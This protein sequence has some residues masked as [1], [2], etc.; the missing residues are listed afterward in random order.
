[1]A[2]DTYAG[3]KTTVADWLHRTDLTAQVPDFISLAERV[4]NRRLN[5]FPREIE[6]SIVAPTSGRTVS[7][8]SDYGQP[9]A[10]YLTDIDPREQLTYVLPEQLN[11]DESASLR[12]HYW[13]VDGANIAFESKSDQAYTMTF[14]YQ[15]NTLLSDSAPM[16]ATFARYPDLYLYGALAQ[17][18]PY[19][20]DDARWPA[21]A[22][23][24]KALL[25]EAAQ[26]ATMTTADA[27][28]RT[29]LVDMMR[30]PYYDGRTEY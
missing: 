21:W 24:F 10:L 13:A 26:D 29:E 3:L 23:N 15:Q 1:M 2:Y 11:V 6:S 5:I 22:A 8:P 4:I 7:L 16:H 18:A 27:E 14:R 9:L 12:P 19:M 20:R 30:R 28:L 25:R 17:A